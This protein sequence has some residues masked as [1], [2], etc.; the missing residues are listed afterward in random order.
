[1]MFDLPE[2]YP[3]NGSHAGKGMDDNGEGGAASGQAHAPSDP[4][5]HEA[6]LLGLIRVLLHPRTLPHV[7]LLG[8]LGSVLHLAANNGNAS[9]SSVGYLS[10]AFGYG[11]TALFSSVPAVKRWTTLGEEATGGNAFKRG[12]FS[13]R[14]C[15]FPMVLAIASGFALLLILGENGLIGDQTDAL[16]LAL[17]GC[18]VAW[19]VLQGRGFS[20]WLEATLVARQTEA[21]PRSEGRTAAS[22]MVA[23]VLLSA[24]ALLLLLA[25]ESLAGSDGEPL[26]SL[27][28]NSLFL[29]VYVVVF[30]GAWW[31]TRSERL[32]ASSSSELHAFSVRWMLVSQGFVSWHLL[33][34]WRHWA[35]APRQSML[36]AE[37]LALMV[38]TVM[39]AIWA[40]TSK[41]FKSSFQLVSKDNALPVGLAF[42]YAYAGSVA[43]MTVVLEDVRNVMMAGHLLVALTVLWVQPRVLRGMLARNEASS[44][45]R[46]IVEKVDVA[47]S[48]AVA[49]DDG[50]QPVSPT[51]ENEG[52]LE[53]GGATS[54]PSEN[55]AIGAEVAWDAPRVLAD[56]V[57]WDDEVELVD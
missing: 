37:E 25:F 14:I 9:F 15:T 3:Q 44:T 10:L 26:D 2:P 33:T 53:E 47:S 22:S 8:V 23:F 7:V 24:I 39:M 6:S 17:A 30:F 43:M 20:R 45:V 19:A 54:A 34:V 41:S 1:M 29:L 40:L 4:Q 51:N 5:G 50:V 35:I 38:F 52:T 32:A 31:R 36:L 16:P 56:G 13:F 49:P 28:S 18:F 21:K 42:G 57:V 55:L 11:L 12:L 48:K 27:L 46:R